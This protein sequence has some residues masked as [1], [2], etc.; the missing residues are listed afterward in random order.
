M[1]E[2]DVK[3]VFILQVQQGS[4]PQP[5]EW[6]GIGI[7]AGSQT[8]SYDVI[9]VASGKVVGFAYGMRGGRGDIPKWSA[10]GLEPNGRRFRIPDARTMKELS[11]ALADPHP[12]VVSE[13]LGWAG[14]TQETE[15][16]MDDDPNARKRL[17]VYTDRRRQEEGLPFITEVYT[18]CTD[19]CELGHHTPDFKTCGRCGARIH[20][21]IIE[22][23]HPEQG[24]LTV[25]S[26][27]VKDIMGWKWSTSHEQAWDTQRVI[28]DYLHSIGMPAA[29]VAKGKD[30]KLFNRTMKDSHFQWEGHHPEGEHARD[31]GYQSIEH[32]FSMSAK[33]IH[34]PHGWPDRIIRAGQDLGFDWMALCHNEWLVVARGANFEDHHWITFDKYTKEAVHGGVAGTADEALDAATKDIQTTW[35][36]KIE[37]GA[38]PHEIFALVYEGHIRTADPSEKRSCAQAH[39][40]IDP[41]RSQSWNTRLRKPRNP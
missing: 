20:K 29:I 39:V 3:P 22:I 10:Y 32:A 35:F 24:A 13:V 33:S 5:Y 23:D 30:G 37:T 1:Q 7:K 17:A 8:R 14:I 15:N 2:Q 40:N 16:P 11:D 18:L 38:D 36:T 25:G 12:I 28:E 21:Q 41:D 31:L 6:A 19:D 27:C 34:T 26:E 4:K 9:H